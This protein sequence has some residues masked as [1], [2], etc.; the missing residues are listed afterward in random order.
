MNKTELVDFLVDQG[1]AKSKAEAGRMLD[2]V[3]SA[4]KEGLTTE[5]KV[6]LSG[7]GTFRVRE[8]AAREGRNPQTGETIQ[9]EAK[10]IVRFKPAKKLKEVV[11]EG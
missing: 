2:G 3:T 8:R 4:I 7:L 11:A 9:I 10:R 5:G 1:V 6:R